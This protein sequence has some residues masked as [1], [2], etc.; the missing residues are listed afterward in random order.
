MRKP[1][2][3]HCCWNCWNVSLWIL[4]DE[5]L[6][7]E[8]RECV[9]RPMLPSGRAARATIAANRFARDLGLTRTP[10]GARYTFKAV[11][12]VM[13]SLLEEVGTV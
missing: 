4:N 13:M 10:D 3:G 5:D 1:C 12:E 7:N 11:R 9:R 6:Y 8:A 2:N